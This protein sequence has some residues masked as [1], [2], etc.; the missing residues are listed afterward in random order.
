MDLE[1]KLKQQSAK[2]ASITED[3][4]LLQRR[5]VEM[6]KQIACEAFM[7]GDAEMNLGFALDAEQA[8]FQDSEAQIRVVIKSW[9]EEDRVELDKNILAQE[10]QPRD[11]VEVKKCT[12]AMM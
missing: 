8:Q 2:I 4:D 12:C 7:R 6:E 5:L 9:E 10:M 3:R 1:A 11:T